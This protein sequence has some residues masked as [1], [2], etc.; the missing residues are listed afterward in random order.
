MIYSVNAEKYKSYLLDASG[1]G[2]WRRQVRAGLRADKK[3]RRNGAVIRLVR[4]GI[5]FMRSG[6]IALVQFLLDNLQLQEHRFHGKS[7]QRIPPSI[8]CPRPYSVAVLAHGT[9]ISR[10]YFDHMYC[11]ISSQ[12][13]ATLSQI[14][15]CHLAIYVGYP[16]CLVPDMTWSTVF[17][18]H[19]HCLM[20]WYF[21][22]WKTFVFFG[23]CA[24]S[25]R[26]TSK[27]TKEESAL[28]VL[29]SSSLPAGFGL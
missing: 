3:R 22:T 20:S 18:C 29:L 2:W 10:A 25:R 13:Y 8:T 28:P 14:D 24:W 17:R 1:E 23:P 19:L 26:T 16:N 11:D 21:Q 4:I 9:R 5:A 12:M 15:K 27:K 6:L 7:L